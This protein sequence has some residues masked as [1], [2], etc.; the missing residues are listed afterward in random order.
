MR[1]NKIKMQKITVKNSRNEI[2]RV[3]NIK[4]KSISA[5]K[6]KQKKEKSK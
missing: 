2:L 4:N 5:E 6:P 1:K 3:V